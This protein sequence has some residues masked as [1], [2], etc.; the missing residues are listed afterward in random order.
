LFKATQFLHC[1]EES[2]NLHRDED[3]LDT[4]F[5][6]GLFP[7][8]VFGWPD[9]SEDMK[10][11]YPTSLLETGLDILFFWVARMVMMGL[12]L[13]DQLPFNTV[14]LHAMVRDKDG[15]KMSKSLGNVI[16]PLEVIDGCT[17]ESLHKKLEAG[18]LP[19]KE[20]EK[21]KKD[22]SDD[23]PDGIPECGSDALRFGLL[24][25]TV[26]GRD[27]NLDIKRVVGYRNFCNKLWNATKFALQFLDDFVPKENLLK[28]LME[29][30]CVNLRDR[31]IISKLM[32]A[33]DK[34]NN[35]LKNYRFGDAQ[36]ESYSFWIDDLCDVYLELIKPVVYNKSH[37]N[38]QARWA[39]QATLWI[40]VETGLRL[41]HPMMPFVTEEL[42]QRLPGRGTLGPDEPETIMLCSYPQVEPLYSNID[43]EGSMETILKIVRSCR[44]L[45]SSYQIPNKTLTKYYLKISGQGEAHVRGQISDVMTL[46]K[47]SSVEINVDQSLLPKSFAIDVVDD[48]TTLLMDIQGLVD[49]KAEVVKLEKNLSK[50]L[51]LLQ[52]LETK[53][54]AAGYE[55]NVSTELKSQNVEKRDSLKKKIDEIEK[56]IENFKRFVIED[57]TR[58]DT[59]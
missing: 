36:Y 37:E 18:N 40:C 47:G 57:T 11:F 44:S 38:A 28:N 17:L 8:S 19:L 34:V 53:M 32:S 16:D 49:F 5:S 54:S 24:A 48:N 27:V 35:H 56:A 42:W 33:C 46:G 12:Q 50:T 51:P 13:T 3:V 20:I 22:Q 26:Q 29:S 21:A 23:F 52:T 31:F 45:R 10:A 14:Y 41:L 9:N 4:W 1:D 7:F 58:A 2:V 39:A 6:S 25:Y 15:R 30:D 59:N 43:L 55:E